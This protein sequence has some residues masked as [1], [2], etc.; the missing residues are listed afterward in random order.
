MKTKILLTF[1]LPVQFLF[2]QY[3]P[4]QAILYSRSGISG[5]ARTAGSA[6]AYGSVGAD[7]GCIGINPAGLGLYRSSDISITPGLKL[8]NN[9]TVYNNSH[10][11]VNAPKFYLGQ[12]G[13]VW[14]KILS[15]SADKNNLSFTTH[16][17]RSI[18]F[19]LNYE[20]ESFFTRTQNFG[21]YNTSNSMVD[22][23]TGYVNATGQSPNG[24]SSPPE[25]QMAYNAGQIGRAHV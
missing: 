3:P 17:L 15:K 9:E 8:G 23:Y 7:L 20:R 16:P 13:A 18:T 12:A 2:A 5:T 14:T 11:N 19:A 10:T 25:I 24:N 6:G 21:A 4:D 22:N 1:L